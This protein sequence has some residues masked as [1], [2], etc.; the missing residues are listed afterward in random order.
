MRL[1]STSTSAAALPYFSLSWVLTLMSHDLTS[2]AVI[3]RLFDFLLAHNPAIISYL[4]VAIV[5]FKKD[6]LA[7]LDEESAEDPAILHH[8]L[9]QLPNLVDTF[10]STPTPA[11][12]TSTLSPAS[13]TEDLMSSR[14]GRDR[15]D[16]IS[17]S[18]FLSESIV[19]LSETS[20]LADHDDFS[21]DVLDDSMLSDPDI[22]GLAFSST[23]QHQTSSSTPSPP[24]R[25]QKPQAPPLSIDNLL[26]K[27]LELW[28][29]YPLLPA[30]T[31]DVDIET[32]T[33]TE[34]INADEVMGPNSCVFT[35]PLS[36]DGLLDDDG[37]NEIARKGEGI[38]LPEAVLE[39]IIKEEIEAEETTSERKK[40]GKKKRERRSRKVEIGTVLAVVGVAGVLLAVYGA[41]EWGSTKN[42][43]RGLGGFGRRWSST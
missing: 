1:T 23:F 32:S 40:G 26:A 39:P 37:A 5:L 29:R 8:T 41:S 16:S 34:S 24:K 7:Q 17:S 19:S 18:S 9:S 43:W 36:V 42:E 25:Q 21:L 11:P 12:P 2:I 4:G 22:H 10:H 14:N 6:A 30:A 28:E 35:W 31:A 27:T 3:A 13:S 33:V 38:V 15:S 20:S